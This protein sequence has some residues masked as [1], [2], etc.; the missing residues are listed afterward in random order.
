MNS[1]L[2]FQY[3][4][5]FILFCISLGVVYALVLYFR[6]RTFDEK[7]PSVRYLKVGMALLRFLAVSLLAV[8][9]L[10]PFLRTRNTQTFKPIIAILH[11]NSESIRMALGKD[12]SL[13]KEQTNALVDKLRDKYEVVEY[14]VGDV[15][16]QGMDFSFSDKA[17]DLSS[18][19]EE[20]N[21]IYYN[22]NLG[23]VVILSDGIYNRGV[24]PVYV[25]DKVPYSIYSVALGDTTVQKDQKLVGAF[26]NKIAY[27]NDRFT[28]RIDVEANNLK[29]RNVKLNVQEVTTGGDA[30]L[31]QQKDVVYATDNFFKSFDFILDA[32]RVGIAHYR[33]SLSNTEGE[34]TYKNNVRDIFVEVL[35]GRQKILL[36]ANSP[37]PDVAAFKSAIESNRNY[38]LDVEFAET[39]SRKV[40]DY[41]LLILHQLPSASQ[42]VQNVLTEAQT[43]KKPLLFVLGSQTLI[44]DF[45]KLQ[46]TLTL[47]SNSARFNDVTPV[48]NQDFNLFT[49]SDK[50]EQTIPKLPPL[51]NFFGDYVANSTAKVL[52]YQK[53]N[54]VTTDFPMWLFSDVGENKVGV[55][56]GEG[57]WRWRLYDY[58][59]NKTHT[60]TNELINKTVQFLSVKADKRPFRISQPK[61]VFQDNEPVV[62]DAQLY[63]ANYELINSPDVKMKLTGENGQGYEYTFNKTEKA[64]ELNAGFLP[65]GNYAYNASVKM[66]NNTL[67]ATGR[68]SVSPLQLE[69]MRTQ[70]DYKVLYQLAT[71]HNGNLFLPKDM[72][73]IAE[74]IE[75]KN[76]LKPLLFDTFQTEGAINLKWIFFLLLILISAEWGIRKYLGGY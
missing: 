9:L 69:E 14:A 8:L 28:L 15:L 21:G 43:Q 36:I 41:N 44:S 17:T 6:D 18:A 37:H 24:N 12:T 30:K 10:S 47:N 46:A 19:L 34:V 33:I 27:L 59:L 26:F 61:S 42:R 38:Q 55:L 67:S 2:S 57:L 72:N 51:S 52:L 49:L 16:R 75:T 65:V 5:W 66:G 45:N 22:R 32:D 1:G 39:F 56:A 53:I 73:K 25:A 13:Y 68:F 29:G 63:N 35:D 62:F 74:E 20:L 64:Y 23:S 71:Q 48:V 76:Q 4:A 11:D 50:T 3:S 58:S 60:A 31:L 7:L 40:N 54:S 70:A